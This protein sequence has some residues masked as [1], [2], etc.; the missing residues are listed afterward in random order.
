MRKRQP[1]GMPH[2]ILYSIGGSLL[3][4]PCDIEVEPGA[5]PFKSDLD[6][7]VSMLTFF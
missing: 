5:Q 4:G 2:S 6:T 3:L 1:W 7:A